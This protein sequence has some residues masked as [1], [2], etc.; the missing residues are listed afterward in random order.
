MSSLQ[1]SFIKP[2]LDEV[3][4]PYRLLYHMHSML[5]MTTIAE[6]YMIHTQRLFCIFYFDIMS[7]R[8]ILYGSSSNC[9]VD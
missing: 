9:A 2:E 7:Y 3:K 8:W 5:L 4:T 6:N 1:L